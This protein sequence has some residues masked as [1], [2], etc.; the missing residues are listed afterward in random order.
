[1]GQ[2]DE[3]TYSITDA[4]GDGICCSYGNGGYVIEVDGIE[5]VNGGQ[6]SSSKEESFVISAQPNTPPTT[7]PP[8]TSPPTTP[9]PTPA[10]TPP[11]T[12]APT[13]PPTPGPTPP[14]TPA[15]FA[16]YSPQP[17]VLPTSGAVVEP[18]SSGPVAPQTC[19][20]EIQKNDFCEAYVIKVV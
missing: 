19:T 18:P 20:F 5:V 9:P 14:P 3:Y 4:Y 17:S 6:F 16:T 15:P 11:P 13:P 10:P 2:P 8:T 12:P 1:M 7:P